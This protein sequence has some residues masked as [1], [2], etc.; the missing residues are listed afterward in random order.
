[1]PFLFCW[2]LLTPALALL[3]V[4]GG[5][6]TGAAQEKARTGEKIA[7]PATSP[8]VLPRVLGET[9]EALEKEAASLKA[10]A[11][12][13]Q[14][15]LS[16]AEK[17][18]RERKAALAGLRAS[19][20]VKTLPLA[21]AQE[22]LKTYAQE[23]EKL[24]KRLTDLNREIE[25]LKKEQ[26]ARAASQA[27]IQE[28]VTRLQDSRHP[29]ARS[30]E[31]QQAH[32][33]YKQA[34]AAQAQA[35]EQLLE[36]LEKESQ[37]LDQ[38]KGQISEVKDEL[39]AHVDAEWK[40]ALLKRQQQLSWGEQARRIWET[41]M[42][43]PVRSWSRL[44]EFYASGE[45]GA[46]F[47]KNAAPLMGLL[48]LLIL[49]AWSVS[50]LGG[51]AAPWLAAWRHQAGTPGLRLLLSLGQSIKE[52]LFL[53]AG[54]L[55]VWV[56]L[57]SLG[58]WESAAWRVFFHLLA[59]LCALGLSRH[60]LKQAFAGEETGGLFPL[61]PL[62]AR[63]YQRYLQLFLTYL[64]LGW[65][66]LASADFLGFPLATRQFLGHLFRLGLLVWTMWLLR[67]R[68]LER[69]LPQLPGPGWFKRTGVLRTLR[70]LV[71]LL[72][73]V[74]ILADLLGFQ[75]LGEY[76]SQ[77][78][79]LTGVVLLLL[80]LLWLGLEVLLH[81]LLHPEEGWIK[82]CYPERQEILQRLH[83]LGRRGLTALVAA[84][85][86]LL[87]MRIWG[88]E[89]GK[90]SWVFQWLTWGPRLGPVR[91][92]PLTL[93]AAALALYLGVWFS[94][95]ARSLMEL[96]VYPRTGW[97]SGVQYTIST[98]LHY[99]ILIVGVLAALNLLGF[100]LTNLA[101]LAGALGVGIGF[102]LQNIVNNFVSGLIL[103]YE[104]PVKVG[105]ILV[106]DG[107]WGTVKEIRVRSTIFE[108]YDRYVLIIPNSEL[109]S[110]KIVNW[111]HHGSGPNRLELKVGVGYG[112]DV[113]R[114]TELVTAICL[115]NPLVQRDPPPQ[116]FFKAYGDSSLDFIIWVF[117]Q[118][119]RDRTAATHEL[120]SA[121][122]HAFRQ[123]GIEI[124]FPKRDLYI[125]NWPE[126]FG[127]GES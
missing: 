65:W 97:D 81:H 123:E 98:T 30:R 57:W 115:A 67:W 10:R 84:G 70:G 20:A 54:L 17:E 79:A 85:A 110:S 72:L 73:A 26:E 43:L 6:L 41:L 68:Y 95:L 44:E 101:L 74:I 51:L 2:R 29:V 38:E 124:P 86:L 8:E 15:A 18:A 7:A 99:S 33:K 22:A 37:L 118:T 93:A 47:G 4:L 56:S 104:R 88:V 21:G 3:L 127:K 31:M 89:P 55:W 23:D 52:R 11:T 111:T 75:N 92:T 96:R 34:A 116:V 16:Q 91:L 108:T 32:K 102:G 63:F 42:S 53:L 71:L 87:A 39:T 61:D 78:G 9:G 119:P 28:E 103:L 66:L 24:G 60:W 35:G 58:I 109:L 13:A 107:Q 82:R 62:T 114:V 100:P 5:P 25:A 125:K 27:A 112:S 94:R 69:L 117:L 48:G 40:A 121:I 59:A 106:I 49:L 46:F 45:L 12:L 50:R 19:L 126:G 77:A 14:K 83:G 120:N 64:V 76:L 90:L 113:G 1:M 122:F 105:D 36:V 80:G